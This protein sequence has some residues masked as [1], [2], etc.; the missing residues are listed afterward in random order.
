[1]KIGFGLITFPFEED[2]I[3]QELTEL[4]RT[5]D[6]LKYSLKIKSKKKRMSVQVILE[7][8]PEEAKFPVD[9]VNWKLV[10]E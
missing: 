10:M 7:L 8:A 5:S 4:G 9:L 2:D 6:N 1:M 3:E